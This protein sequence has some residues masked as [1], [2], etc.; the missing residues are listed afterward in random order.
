M[1][2]VRIKKKPERPRDDDHLRQVNT[3][4]S[5]FNRRVNKVKDDAKWLADKSG[6][7][8][9]ADNVWNFKRE[10]DKYSADKGLG[11]L[12]ENWKNPYS[13]DQ[14]R[15]AGN[16]GYSTVE[17]LGDMLELGWRVPTAF[18]GFD[19]LPGDHGVMGQYFA[20]AQE[21][22][23]KWNLFGLDVPNPFADELKISQ[24]EQA[25]P[26]IERE[27]GLDD[28]QNLKNA[29]DI[30]NI[31]NFQ[32][33]LRNYGLDLEGLNQKEKIMAYDKWMG[34][35][36]FSQFKDVGDSRLMTSG[37]GQ[38]AIPNE[39]LESLD[40]WD[41]YLSLDQDMMD[42]I[43]GDYSKDYVDYQQTIMKPIEE[44][45]T[46]NLYNQRDQML[47]DQFG[48]D[49]DELLFAMTKG[50]ANN[51]DLGIFEDLLRENTMPFMEDDFRFDYE[52]DAA[53]KI[54]EENPF[55][56]EGLPSLLGWSAGLKAL[57]LPKKLSSTPPD[58]A[59][60]L[61]K[62]YYNMFPGL[63]GTGGTGIPF[64][65]FP[66]RTWTGSS[67]NPPGRSMWQ[68]PALTYGTAL[69]ETGDE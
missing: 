53:Q 23:P 65:N 7:A 38:Y 5:W 24:L 60:I 15:W 14:Y 40:Y 28:F 45:F 51:L 30:F 9:F 31:V 47:M 27:I 20:G 63:S 56:S 10:R 18:A 22:D 21:Y 37:G 33:H 69:R 62:T 26:D 41:P 42:T 48:L 54:Y 67:W 2:E 49:K 50:E 55:W 64:Y 61:K 29:S 3:P 13:R 52:T 1:V 66:S 44:K 36:Y 25:I 32:N 17:G 59:G 43:V 4:K 39:F 19:T 8:N 35:K 46:E 57:K 11:F 16:L 58:R 6:I 12:E 34:D 68:F